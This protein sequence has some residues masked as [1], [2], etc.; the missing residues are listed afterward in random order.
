MSTNKDN[1]P[2]KKKNEILK[3]V[4]LAALE[5]FLAVEQF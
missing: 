5:E 2:G 4:W 1:G 3:I